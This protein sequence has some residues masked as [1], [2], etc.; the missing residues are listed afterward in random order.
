MKIQNNVSIYDKME[1]DDEVFCGPSVVF[2]NVRHPRAHVSRH[3]TYEATHVGRHTTLNANATMMCKMQV[4]AYALI[5]ADA[6]V[7]ADVA[8]YALVVGLPARQIGWTCQC[9]L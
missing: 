1:L 7:T 4:G 3:H 8:P 6:V 9:G 5:N 2:T